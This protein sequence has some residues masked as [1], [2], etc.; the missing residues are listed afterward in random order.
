MTNPNRLLRFFGGLTGATE[1]DPS[2]MCV[3]AGAVLFNLISFR[4]A[5]FDGA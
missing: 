5:A 2:M 3:F 4:Y 1:F